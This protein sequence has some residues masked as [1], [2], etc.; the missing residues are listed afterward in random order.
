MLT[1]G[2]PTRRPLRGCCCSSA[3]GRRGTRHSRR[4]SEM[5]K[6]HFVAATEIRRAPLN[7]NRP[8][9]RERLRPSLSRGMEPG[10]GGGDLKSHSDAIFHD[11]M[12][13]PIKP[14]VRCIV[15][16]VTAALCERGP[17]TCRSDSAAGFRENEAIGLASRSSRA[18]S[19]WPPTY[20][21]VSLSLTVSS[22]VEAER[23]FSALADGGQA[24]T[25]LAKTFFPRALAWLLTASASHEWSMSSPKD[26]ASFAN[27]F[28]CIRRYLLGRI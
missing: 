15:R 17:L 6:R 11:G 3:K 25:P 5:T 10:R 21:V 23:F 24:Q 20:W 4:G 28:F 9:D 13:L 7:C 1:V 27:M 14:F 12:L 26:S 19:S 16:L 8:C 22:D 2:S 18:Q